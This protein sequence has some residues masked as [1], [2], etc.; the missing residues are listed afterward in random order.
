MGGRTDPERFEAFLADWEAILARRV[1]AA[2]P[3][4]AA[5]DGVCGLLLAGGIGRGAP[6]PL[7]DIDLLPV[8]DDDRVEAARAEV[9]RRR[10]GLL[11]RWVVEGWWTGLDLGRLAFV[12]SE[13]VLALAP[14]GPGVTDLLRDDRWYHALDKGYRGRAVYD[15]DDLAA[16]LARW[17][18]QH[19]FER[20]V[21]RF[22]LLRARREVVAAERRVRASIGGHDPVSATSALRSAVKWLQTWMLEGWGERDA[23]LG[24][25]GTRFERLAVAHGR[26][27]QADVLNA[28]SDLD[29]ASVERRMAAAPG[30]VGERHDRSWRARRH[31]GEDVTRLQ[32]ARDTLRVCSLYAARRVSAPPFPA[33]LAIPTEVRPLA[34]KAARLSALIDLWFADTP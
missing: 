2:V 22:R 3:A 21:V 14:D 28:L 31:V 20:S 29:E 13:A 8:Y 6:W 16:P 10:V 18:T 23:S 17:F 30:W 5:V 4:F 33:W 25:L 1:D 7:S 24:R 19:R 12:R 32:D 34:D 27:E 9:E 11:G 15:P 26:P